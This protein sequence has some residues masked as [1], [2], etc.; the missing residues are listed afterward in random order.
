MIMQQDGQ[1]L[2]IK[3]YKD[4]LIEYQQERPWTI[5]CYKKAMLCFLQAQKLH[6]QDSNMYVLMCKMY[7]HG[8]GCK[9][10][11]NQA[12]Q[13]LETA[14][15]LGNKDAEL[16]D[17]VPDIYCYV[18]DYFNPDIMIKVLLDVVEQGKGYDIHQRVLSII[19]G[20]QKCLL[21]YVEDY[22]ENVMQPKARFFAN[23]IKLTVVLGN[24]EIACQ[25]MF[26]DAF[27]D[28]RSQVLANGI[29][30]SIVM[31]LWNLFKKFDASGLTDAVNFIIHYS[32]QDA[33]LMCS[34][35][36]YCY[37]KLHPPRTA[38]FFSEQELYSPQLPEGISNLAY[39]AGLRANDSGDSINAIEYF[40]MVLP[41][42]SLYSLARNKIESLEKN[43]TVISAG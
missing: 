42:T 32:K 7:Y 18:S 4:G 12:L 24:E 27:C 14:Y 5:G 8:L 43:S 19:I 15:S 3:Y 41:N 1:E 17:I 35:V 22:P 40:K 37:N 36:G 34:F 33:S 20:K 26:L 9:C 28:T 29:F 2:A 38:Q 25:A 10:D 16:L 31:F 23:L 11:Y 30:S 13:C 6:C 21:D 39:S